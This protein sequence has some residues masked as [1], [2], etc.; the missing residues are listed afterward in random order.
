MI[1][2]AAAAPTNPKVSN[3]CILELAAKTDLPHG[4]LYI[5]E[6]ELVLWNSNSVDRLCVCEILEQFCVSL[7]PGFDP[8]L[9]HLSLPLEYSQDDLCSRAEGHY[10]A[11]VLKTGARKLEGG[12]GGMEAY[13]ICNSDLAT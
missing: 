2:A 13:F 3:L 12:L 5:M 4:S 8:S 1:Q 7:C 9:S 10:L 6:G 11:V